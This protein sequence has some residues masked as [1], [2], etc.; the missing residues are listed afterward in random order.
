MDFGGWE[1]PIQYTS[2]LAEHRAVRE[3][4]GWFDVSHLGRF[5][6]SGEGAGA[7]L[8]RLLCNDHERIG[9]GPAPSTR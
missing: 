4:V 5:S 2:V 8:S 7:A 1:M 3:S 6:W 9:A